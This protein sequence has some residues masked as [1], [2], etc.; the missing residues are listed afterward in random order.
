MI[1][2]LWKIEPSLWSMS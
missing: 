2:I 1:A